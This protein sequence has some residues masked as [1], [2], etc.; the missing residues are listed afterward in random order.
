VAWLD[1]EFGGRD[2]DWATERAAAGCP[3][4][5]VQVTPRLG[6]TRGDVDTVHRWLDQVTGRVEI[7]QA[8]RE[9]VDHHSGRH[10]GE[11][12]SADA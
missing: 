6:L 4:L 8:T 12:R 1:D 5:L 7:G 9:H 3:T 10:G 11:G 2:R